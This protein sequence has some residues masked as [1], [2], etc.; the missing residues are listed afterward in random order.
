M[1]TDESY[2]LKNSSS[3]YQKI[4]KNLNKKYGHVNKNFVKRES[5]SS[6]TNESVHKGHNS[7]R[8][9]KTKLDATTLNQK[10]LKEEKQQE[11]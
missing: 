11:W 8:K 6:E 1:S 4:H 7:D 2:P 10:K 9:L 5:I 3:V